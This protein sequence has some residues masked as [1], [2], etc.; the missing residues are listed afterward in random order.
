MCCRAG[1]Q[2]WSILALGSMLPVIPI[3]MDLGNSNISGTLGPELGQLKHLQYLE[4]YRNEISGKIPK[5]LGNLKN[6]IGMDLYDNKFEGKIPKSLA[7]LKSL[8][9][10]R[11]NNN[12]LTGSIPRELTTLSNLKIFD[13]SNNDL[14]GTIPV[15]GPFTTFPMER[16][17]AKKF[18]RCFLVCLCGHLA[19]PSTKRKMDN[20]LLLRGYIS[21]MKAEQYCSTFELNIIEF[22][23]SMNNSS[24]LLWD[25]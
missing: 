25:V 21:S 3:T 22:Y 24:C 15:D 9:F 4:L 11:L 1:T 10:L 16:F 13:V 6:L 14:C 18:V 7:K 23:S 12:K 19:L 5:E 2:L 8:K 20:N 17:L